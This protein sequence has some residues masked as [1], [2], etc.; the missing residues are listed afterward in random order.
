MERIGE[1]TA[2][3]GECVEITFC[4]PTDCGKCHACQ[5]ARDRMQVTVKGTAEV[6]DFAVVDMPSATVMKASLLAYVLPLGG[7]LAGV[8]AGTLLFP[9]QEAVA[10]IVGGAMGLAV[11]LG[12][13]ALT[14]KKRRNDP[15]W[16][17]QLLRVIPKAECPA[18]TASTG[19]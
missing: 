3:R 16:R 18:V 14:E 5:G 12:A 13:V 7:L 11:T 8:A 19:L 1:V 17:P 9:A 4:R 10:G 6:G 2:V 15:Q